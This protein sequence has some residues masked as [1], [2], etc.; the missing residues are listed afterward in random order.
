M[1]WAKFQTVFNDK[2]YS[3]VVRAKFAP[4]VVP[5]D[6]FHREKFLREL[7][8]MIHRDVV[9]TT[10]DD[11]TTY[12]WTID[13]ALTAERVENQVWRE[14]GARRDHERTGPSHVGPGRG[15]GSSN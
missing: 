15:N 4:D 12:T 14:N 13:K 1:T 3:T 9:I 7:N 6:R 11:C 8:A 10:D 2:Y 5:N